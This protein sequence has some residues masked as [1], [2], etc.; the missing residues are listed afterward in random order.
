M[1]TTMTK[2]TRRS[3]SKEYKA[4]VVDLVRQADG[5][6]AKVAREIGLSSQIVGAWVRQSLVDAGKGKPEQ[7]TSAEREELSKLRK[8][9]KDLRMEREFLK[10]ISTWFA[11]E[12]K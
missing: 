8:E 3:F 4:E 12:N 6:S 11:R 5:N 9:N 10:K 2:R 1:D 7:L